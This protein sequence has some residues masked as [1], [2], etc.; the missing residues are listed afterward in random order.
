MIYQLLACNSSLLGRSKWGYI[1]RFSREQLPD[2][3]KLSAVVN[4]LKGRVKNF[5]LLNLDGDSN[6]SD[7]DNLLALCVSMHDQHEF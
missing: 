5:V 2:I 1:N 7:L 3:I 4:G 6:F